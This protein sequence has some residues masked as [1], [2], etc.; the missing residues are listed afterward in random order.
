MTR[1][2]RPLPAWHYPLPATHYPLEWGSP[3]V[4]GSL[5]VLVGAGVGVAVGLGSPATALA[6]SVG[7]AA[8]VAIASSLQVGLLALV[9][10]VSLLPF[11]V[12]PI[13]FG[14]QLTVVDALLGALL[15]GWAVRAI[16]GRSRLGLPS[17]T[18]PLVL[19]IGVAVAAL[20][21]GAANAPLSGPVV[22]G[23]LKYAAAILLMVAVANVVRTREQVRAVVRALVLCGA[24]AA[25]VALLIQALPR[26]T[27]IGLLSGLSVV[28]YPSGPEVLRFRP[29]PND[30]YTDVLRATGTS[31]DP[32]VLGGLLMLATALMLAQ[33]F[34]PRPVVPRPALLPLAAVTGAAMVATD[35]R[36]SWVG[37][38]AAG[39]F[40]ATFRY[41][42]LWLLAIPA[43]LA[44]LYLP[45]GQEMLERLASG[46]AARDRAAALRLD[47]YR[48]ALRLIAAYPLLG[49]GFGGAPE[50][51]TFV[52]VSSIYLLVGEQT[53]LLGLALY[54][55]TLAALLVGSLRVR[56]ACPDDRGLMTTLQAP[57]IAALT[58]GLF[59]HYFMNPRFPHMVALFW[60]YAGLLQA[61]TDM[62]RG[63][64]TPRSAPVPPPGRAGARST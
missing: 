23:F 64:L 16:A 15:V 56:A 17:A 8:A 33:W 50:A 11:A 41:R 45:V 24:L 42:K 13:R 7:L 27:I 35:S 22:R 34:A 57:L 18:R 36:S 2:W 25:A 12:I 39:A 37:L 9:A 61:T 26:P 43:A 5:A 44:L 62:A 51:G 30:T 47:E 55:T 59:D 46:F 10:V 60:L 53:G 29:G 54:L 40:L 49:V 20:L 21:A 31:I 6:S 38:A 52:G 28:G 32:N 1:R 4:A 19:Y 3:I 48:Q 63:A 58:A 14:V